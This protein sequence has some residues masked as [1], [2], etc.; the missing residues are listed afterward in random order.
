[1]ALRENLREP[2]VLL[3]LLR[4]YKPGLRNGCTEKWR[5]ENCRFMQVKLPFLPS[6]QLLEGFRPPAA[7]GLGAT[8]KLEKQR[9]SRTT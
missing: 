6:F 7:V 4:N 5:Q 3:G 9:F 2:V 8:L 1:M